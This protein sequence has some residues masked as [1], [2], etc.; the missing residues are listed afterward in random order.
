LHTV[1]WEQFAATYMFGTRGLTA[2]IGNAL[3][4]ETQ[5]VDCRLHSGSIGYRLSAAHLHLCVNQ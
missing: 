1:T 4:L 3:D 5:I 2:A